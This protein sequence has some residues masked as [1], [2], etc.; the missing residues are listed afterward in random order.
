M[1]KI[2]FSVLMM[3]SVGAQAQLSNGP[4]HCDNRVRPCV[5]M[6]DYGSYYGQMMNTAANTWG[7]GYRAQATGKT[8]NGTT[9]LTWN[10]SGVVTIPGT[11]TVTGAITGTASAVAA[12]NVTAGSLPSTVIASSIAVNAV[13]DASLFGSITP[14]K[15]TGT[16]AVLT[17]NTFSGQ[18]VPFSA[19]S[20]TIATLLPAGLGVQI[21][22]TT[23]NAICMSTA[24]VAGAWVFQS[25]NPITTDGISCKE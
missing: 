16:A 6:N 13:K 10:T 24:V 19:S 21:Y 14:S 8:V 25:T 15:I 5:T 12:A 4:L 2:I 3:V 20:T 23:R 17:G 11:L 18:N 7:L 22:N 9:A 1:N